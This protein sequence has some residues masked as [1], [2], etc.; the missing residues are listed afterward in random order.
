MWTIFKVFKIV[1]I[2]LLFCFGVFFGHEACGILVAWS[3]IEHTTHALKDEVLTTG[4]PGKSHYILTNLTATQ[5]QTETI[6]KIK[7]SKIHQKV[8]QL[9]RLLF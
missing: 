7:I 4:P 9:L 3:G 6:Y 5:S 2:L 1:A 8:S